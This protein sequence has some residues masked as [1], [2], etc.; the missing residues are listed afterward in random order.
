[1]MLSE[2]GGEVKVLLSHRTTQEI[3]FGL[4]EEDEKNKG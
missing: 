2:G 4:K 3:P 1:M